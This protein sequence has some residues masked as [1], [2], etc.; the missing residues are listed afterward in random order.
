MDDMS[1]MDMSG[2][3]HMD[4]TGME[5]MSTPMPTLTDTQVAALTAMGGLYAAFALVLGIV[6]IVASWKIF[7]KAGQAGWKSVIPLYNVYVLLKIVGRPGWWLLL[8]FIPVVNIVISLVVSIDLG[9]SFGKSTAYSVVLLW[10][11]SLIGYCLLAFG[12]DQYIGPGGVQMATPTEVPP[13]AEP[14]AEPS[15]PEPQVQL[16]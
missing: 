13:S 6:A 12:N 10:L 7:S 5:A 8:F 1:N 9:K 2:M 11:L 14:P 4:H 15:A 3:E 16:T